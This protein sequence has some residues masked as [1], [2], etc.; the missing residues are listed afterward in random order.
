MKNLFTDLLIVLCAVLMICG[1]AFGQSTSPGTELVASA[2]TDGSR[3]ISP[4]TKPLDVV[5][6]TRDRETMSAAEIPNSPGSEK[7]IC[8]TNA[9]SKGTMQEIPCDQV[10]KATPFNEARVIEAYKPRRNPLKVFYDIHRHPQRTTVIWMIG[11]GIA[12]GLIAWETRA[13]C[14]HYEYGHNGVNVNCPKE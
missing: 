12:G 11:A 1:A 2:T 5:G 7:R 14:D 3:K 13:H 9:D 8:Y 6:V 4:G 10:P